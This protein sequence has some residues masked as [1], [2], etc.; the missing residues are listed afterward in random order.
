[1]YQRHNILISVSLSDNLIHKMA[2]S[3][4]LYNTHQPTK[5]KLDKVTNKC[6]IGFVK[7]SLSVNIS[8]RNFVQLI[9]VSTTNAV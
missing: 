7:T 3:R 5:I 8:F 1:M 9:N 2:L 4:T 6:N